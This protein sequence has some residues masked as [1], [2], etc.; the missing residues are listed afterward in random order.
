MAVVESLVLL[1]HKTHFSDSG[2]PL[3]SA[4]DDQHDWVSFFWGFYHLM[5][6][7]WSSGSSLFEKN[8]C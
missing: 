6:S 3:V 8:M 4:S 2:I 7:G 5:Y 1:R